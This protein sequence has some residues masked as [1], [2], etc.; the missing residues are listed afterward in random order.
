MNIILATKNN[1]KVTEMADILAPYGITVISQK[2]A[3]IDVDVIETGL[4]FEENAEIKARAVS[5]LC[6]D[7]VLADDSGLCIDAL[8]GKPGIFSA[9]YGGEQLPYSE[10][11]KGI[12]TE[13]EGAENRDAHF[14]CSMVLVY[15]DGKKISSTGIVN[16]EILTEPKGTG[17]FGYDSIFYCN[18]LR[19]SFGEATEEEKNAVSHRGKALKELCDKIVKAKEHN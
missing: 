10:K 19:K 11:I 18:E 15:P 17:G 9:R 12:L 3:G 14:E 16:G 7:P 2:D 8:G 1:G 4:T 13:L 5:M 6:D